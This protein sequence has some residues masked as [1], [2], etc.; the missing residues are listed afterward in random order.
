MYAQGSYKIEIA[1][2]SK[3]ASG[4]TLEVTIPTPHFD[5]IDGKLCYRMPEG[6]SKEGEVYFYSLPIRASRTTSVQLNAKSLDV[7]AIGGTLPINI[8]DE[9]ETVISPNGTMIIPKRNSVQRN[10]SQIPTALGA[11]QFNYAGKMRG[12]DVG[13]VKV[14]IAQLSSTS[15]SLSYTKSISLTVIGPSNNSSISILNT[16]EAF[17]ASGAV[18]KQRVSPIQSGKGSSA[19]AAEI[20]QIPGIRS[21]DGAIYRM[22]VNRTGIYKIT[23]DDLKAFRIDPSIIDTKT[24]RLVS[25]GQQIPLYIFDHFDG[26]IDPNDY[27]EFYGEERLLKGNSKFGDM[28]YD[29]YTHENVYYLVWGTRYSPMPAGGLKRMV[30]ESG[31]I[32]EASPSKYIDLRD[33]SFISTLHLE[34]DNYFDKLDITDLLDVSS[35]RDHWFMSPVNVASSYHYKAAVPFPDFTANSRIS[36]RVALHGLTHFDEGY[37]GTHGEELPVIDSE[38]RVQVN[39]NSQFLLQDHWDSQILKF[40]STDTLDQRYHKDSPTTAILNK[41]GNFNEG[42]ENDFEVE[43]RLDTSIGARFAINWFELKYPRKFIAFQNRLQFSIPMGSSGGLYQFTLGGFSRSDISIYRLGVS[44]L[45][46]IFIGDTTNGTS[47]Y[48]TIIQLQ[49]AS[50]K[51]QFLAIVDTAKLKPVRYIR[52]ED[53]INLRDASTATT[54]LIITSREHFDK[55]HELNSDVPLITLAKYYE[56]KKGITTK[57][58]DVANIFDDF[59]F[60]VKSPEAIKAFLTYAYHNWPTPVKSVFIVGS[61]KQLSVKERASTNLEDEVPTPYVQ[62]YLDG[63]SAADTWYSLL[64]GDDLLPDILIGRL[65][66]ASIREDQNYVDKIINYEL[67]N[68]DARWRMSAF[69]I[70]GNKFAG[71]PTDFPLQISEL[72]KSYVPFNVITYRQGADFGDYHGTSSQLVA[73]VNSGVGYMHFMGHGGS[74]IWA[75]VASSEVTPLLSTNDIKFLTNGPRYPFVTSLTCYTG[76]YDGSYSEAI[77]PSLLLAKNAGIIG[78]LATSSFGFR[79]NDHDLAKG[80][81]PHVFDS[82]ERS[83]GDRVTQGKI[84]YFLRYGLTNDDPIAK[85]L[86]LCYSYLGD[87]IVTPSYARHSV[88]ATLSTRTA[89]PGSS[90]TI[91][92]KTTIGAGFARVELV[93]DQNSPLIPPHI[94]D[95]VKITGGSFTVADNIPS[96][97][98]SGAGSYKVTAYN[99]FDD[100]LASTYADITFTNSRVSELR[101]ETYP[102]QPGVAAT[103]TAAVQSLNG[104]T[105]VSAA[106][107]TYRQ[108]ATGAETSALTTLALNPQDDKYTLTIPGNLLTDGDRLEVIVNVQDQTG[109]V[110][111]SSP[112]ITRVGAATDPAAFRDARHTSI[113][114]KLA[115]GS[116]GIVFRAKIYNWGSIAARNVQAILNEQLPIGTGVLAQVTI[117]VIEAKSFV[118]YDFPLSNDELDTSQIF[119]TI[120]PEGGTSPLNLRDSVGYND[121][122]AVSYLS[123]GAFVYKA[124]IGSTAD[125]TTHSDVFFD[126]RLIGVEL[127]PQALSSVTSEV[128]KVDRI[129]S[130]G[131]IIQPD[132]TLLPLYGS[133]SLSLKAYRITS[134]SLGSIPLENPV[135]VRIAINPNDSLIRLHNNEPLYIYHQNDRT[136]LWTILPTTR[137]GDTLIGESLNLG[138]FAFGYHTDTKAPLIDMTVEGQVFMDKG[139]VPDHPHVSAVLQDANGIDVTPGKTIVKIDNRQL[140]AQEYSLLDSGRTAS[141]VSLFLNPALSDGDHVVSVQATD[142]NGNQSAVKELRMHVSHDFVINTLGSYPN[143]FATQMFLAYE[144]K[145][146]PF[147]EQVELRVYTVSG[148]MIRVLQFPSDNPDRTFGFLKGGTGTPTSLGY[149]EIWW[150]GRDDGGI[151]VANGVYFYKLIVKTK[152][153]SRE[154]TGKFARVR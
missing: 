72:L 45:S 29:P 51:D 125:G 44:K 85:D 54:H 48:R 8:S 16:K 80:L 110:I 19:L 55:Y 126:N 5:T 73:R 25:G 11:V 74:G 52:D 36:L 33:S 93:D 70:A 151:D 124:D 138:T 114:G 141:T 128:V 42:F 7:L 90:V 88:T 117:P 24:L 150:D 82:T 120:Q 66:S 13:R 57:V 35:R 79:N 152:E 106:V 32:R 94:I 96:V 78:G 118:T 112:L 115:V 15:R 53:Y 12:V 107:R 2:K 92:G 75:D 64:D 134:D 133:H 89:A 129:A 10:T 20:S 109:K 102:V 50:D 43:N 26:K 140:D 49:V 87:P 139:E 81:L 122:S 63:M 3:S 145:G 23:Y 38:N 113:E 143:P 31:E 116:N 95:S 136:K 30:E 71:S 46:N 84:D 58:I 60:G 37:L 77:I 108:D 28:Y 59:S 65:P 61:A 6:V 40:I 22:Y 17:Q 98:P 86:M 97:L 123:R 83:W 148:R 76:A 27:L 121:T 99:L 104:I 4:S 39:I 127:Q 56:Q 144:I 1:E 105:S 147:A 146:I 101:F 100:R 21:D 137:T 111:S 41:G 149:H 34:Q 62:A 69:F 154:L 91:N 130:I 132:I 135:K 18:V 9:N 67:P 47:D 14:V 131:E 103:V 153:D 119:L 68:D 142:N